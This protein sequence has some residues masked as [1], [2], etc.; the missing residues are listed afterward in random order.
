MIPS[1]VG[2]LRSSVAGARRF[3]TTRPAQTKVAVLGAAG[4]FPM[5]PMCF[6]YYS[7]GLLLD[8]NSVFYVVEI[9]I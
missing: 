7:I 5:A 1:R 3:S 9:N 4:T 8:E 6:L 2:L